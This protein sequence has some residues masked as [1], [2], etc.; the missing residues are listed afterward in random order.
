MPKFPEDFTGPEVDRYLELK[1]HEM[2]RK[3]K[4]KKLKEQQEQDQTEEEKANLQEL[5][6]KEWS[7][8]KLSKITM[9]P[10]QQKTLFESFKYK[11]HF[12][13]QKF[14]K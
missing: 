14:R 12:L 7:T 5:M 13:G 1:F 6:D 10:V 9:V 2:E 3:L 11:I 4:E 8:P